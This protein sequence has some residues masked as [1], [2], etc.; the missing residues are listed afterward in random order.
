VYL[1]NPGTE[2][3]TEIQS[4]T[5]F[6]APVIAGVAAL[7]RQLHPDS[8]ASAQKIRRA[9]MVTARLSDHPN[10]LLGNGLAR[11]AAAHCA[12]LRDSLVQNPVCLPPAPPSAVKGVLVWRGGQVRT[13]TWPND[14]DLDRARMWD[15]KGRVFPLRGS[16]NEDGEIL[17][18]SP[19]RLAPGTFILRIPRLPDGVE[20]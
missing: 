16:L 2:T 15:L 13:M 6:A 8:T 1:A 17:L 3:G 5:S 12:L 18:R 10:D 19:R 4:G 9:L 14:L 20:P 11:A 7:L